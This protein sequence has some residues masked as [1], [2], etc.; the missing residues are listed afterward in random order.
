MQQAR[1]SEI[2]DV[3]LITVLKQVE[4]EYVDIHIVW[5][6]GHVISYCGHV[7]FNVQNVVD[8]CS[9]GKFPANFF[10]SVGIFLRRANEILTISLAKEEKI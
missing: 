1:R 2:F 5:P 6:L 4:I 7:I 3:M 9:D 8:F 10:P